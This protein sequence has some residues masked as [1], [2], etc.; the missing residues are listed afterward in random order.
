MTEKLGPWVSITVGFA[1]GFI[2]VAVGLKTSSNAQR[3]RSPILHFF[4]S[5]AGFDPGNGDKL[6]GQLN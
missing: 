1:V 5:A 2:V 3:N 4:G 6:K